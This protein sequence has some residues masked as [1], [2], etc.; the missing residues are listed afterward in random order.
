MFMQVELWVK[1]LGR[2]QKNQPRT[3]CRLK[4]ERERERERENKCNC[5][6]MVVQLWS[7]AV[8]PLQADDSNA[9]GDANG[10]KG[11][12]LDQMFEADWCNSWCV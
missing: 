5:N 1:Y 11:Q 10:N 12:Q 3:C 6:A 4:K 2:F 8:R 7:L 9:G